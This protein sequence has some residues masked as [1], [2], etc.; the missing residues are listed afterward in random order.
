MP[1]F[2]TREPYYY[3]QD[4]IQRSL[5][6]QFCASADCFQAGSKPFDTS[7]VPCSEPGFSLLE[8]GS[9][10]LFFWA[11][12]CVVT[13]SNRTPKTHNAISS[14]TLGDNYTMRTPRI[15]SHVH[16]SLH[17]PPTLSKRF[18]TLICTHKCSL[19]RYAIKFC[20]FAS[21]CA[22]GRAVIAFWRPAKSPTVCCCQ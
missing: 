19:F 4:S 5:E 2:V 21:F 1:L 22:S 9:V 13:T 14:H 16:S 3:I 15:Q 20:R 18:K 17:A 6:S 10:G 12:L 11:P 8:Q 7:V